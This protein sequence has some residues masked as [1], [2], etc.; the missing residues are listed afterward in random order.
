MN[1]TLLE[2]LDGRCHRQDSK[3]SIC[4]Q[5]QRILTTR[6]Y[7]YAKDGT[8]SYVTAFGIPELL[9]QYA[10]DSSAH[11]HFRQLIRQ[12]LLA[13]EPRLSDVEVKTIHAH[14]LQASC[15]LVLHT[16]QGP[17]EELFFF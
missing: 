6:C 14:A 9:E 7:R 2:K 10:G 16:E 5:V 8:G 17:I 13:L 15:Q 12:Q 1:R 3:Q 11:L 4:Q